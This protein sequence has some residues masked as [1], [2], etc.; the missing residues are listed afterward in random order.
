MKVS[1]P[2]TSAEILLKCIPQRN[3]IVMVDTLYAFNDNEVS[4]GLSID[5]S[6]Y[7]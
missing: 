2:I 1:F 6:D 3:P 4:A 5:T 7:L